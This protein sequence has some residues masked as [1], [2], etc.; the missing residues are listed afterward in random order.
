MDGTKTIIAFLLFFMVSGV[1][2][3]SFD[4]SIEP[5]TNF[6]AKQFQ[7]DENVSGIQTAKITVVNTGS[8]GCSFRAR[9]V[10]NNSKQAYSQEKALWPGS[11][12]FLEINENFLENGTYRGALYLEYCGQQELIQE[13]NFTAEE[14]S[15]NTTQIKSSTVN[16][17]SDKVEV[18]LPVEK[19]LIVPEETPSYWKVS[20][21]DIVNGTTEIGLE[22]PIFD[23]REKL[24]FS[25][26][27]RSSES[28][29]GQTSVSLTEPEPGEW[30]KRVEMLKDRSPQIILASVLLNL[31][32]VALLIRK[33]R[34]KE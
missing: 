2:A 30:E 21:S 25:I 34:E 16:V 5:D 6:S 12:G 26:Y 31:L 15:G 28:F 14:N 11:S 33:H 10:F 27:N 29:V 8:V 1:S 17:D 20:S 18:S 23:E 24:E 13:Y 32:L 4:A 22:A 7:F 3:I 9:S 19:G